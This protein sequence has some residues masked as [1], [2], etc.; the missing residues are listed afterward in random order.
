MKKHISIFLCFLVCSLI[1]ASTVL[2]QAKGEK[3]GAH[4]SGVVIATG[5]MA[6]GASMWLDM[7]V[8]KFT[9]DEDVVNYLTILKEKGQDALV[10]VLE[11]N[12]VGR[13][14][15]PTGGNVY[16]A[17]A[18][19]HESETGTIVRLFTARPMLFL[20]RYQGTRSTGYPISLIELMLDKD[21]NGQGAVIAAAKVKI[22]NN[23]QFELESFGNQYIKI[24][25]VRRVD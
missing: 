25:N 19:R 9:T 12:D 20:E 2:A 11:K 14:V 4:Y 1:Q 24:A 23:N 13:V 10:R 21:G 6:G 8:D 16:L 17:V 18:R 3:K 7:Y 5:G 15:A 22:T